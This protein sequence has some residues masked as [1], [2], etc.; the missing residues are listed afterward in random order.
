MP[1]CLET[2]VGFGRGGQE[3]RFRALVREWQCIVAEISLGVL[4]TADLSLLHCAGERVVVD[5]QRDHSVTTSW[6]LQLG[7]C[8]GRMQSFL[9]TLLAGCS[10]VGR[11]RQVSS[12]QVPWPRTGLLHHTLVFRWTQPGLC[13]QRKRR[14]VDT[15][16]ARICARESRRINARCFLAKILSFK[17][18]N[19]GGVCV[20]LACWNFV[21]HSTS[22]GLCE[23][24]GL[25]LQHLS[26]LCWIFAKY[27]EV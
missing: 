11:R 7:R 22:M 10:P 1:E 24:H 4:A 17:K 20:F 5:Y 9:W 16:Q 26:D 2:W 12:P 18:V 6:G 3:S 27:Y 8:S 25:Y 13:G 23:I 19:Q 14:C 15:K 21:N